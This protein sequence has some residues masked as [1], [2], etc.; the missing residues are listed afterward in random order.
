MFQNLNLFELIPL[1]FAVITVFY[2]G[3][4]SGG[5]FSGQRHKREI[6]KINKEQDNPNNRLLRT[7]NNNDSEIVSEGDKLKGANSQ[8]TDKTGGNR[9]KGSG[10]VKSSYSNNCRRMDMLYSLLQEN[11]ALEQ[12]QSELSKNETA[13]NN[14]YLQYQLKNVQKRHRLLLKIFDDDRA[15]TNDIWNVFIVKEKIN[16]PGG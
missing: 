14:D 3:F 15:F 12:L 5:F 9:R 2:A 13:Q 16:R 1:S 10:V 6:R 4:K 11:A 7:R 8:L